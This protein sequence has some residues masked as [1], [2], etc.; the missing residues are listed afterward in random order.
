LLRWT[1]AG[2]ARDCTE[3]NRLSRPTPAR[4]AINVYV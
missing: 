3:P 4:L 2:T 1:I